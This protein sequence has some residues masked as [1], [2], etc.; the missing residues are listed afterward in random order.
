MIMKNDAH[1]I[2]NYV[3]MPGDN[4]LFDANIWLFIYGPQGDPRDW[5]TRTYSKSLANALK[6][7]SSLYIDV[8]VLSEF[9]NRYA[10]LEHKLQKASPYR[11]KTFRDSS[12]FKPIAKHIANDVRRIVGLCIRT[13]SGFE[14]VDIADLLN[15]F[16]RGNSDFN[17]QVL[18][19]LCQT[20]GLTLVTHDADFKDCGVA[21]L[22]ANRRLLA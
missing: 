19:A 2:T 15:E 21:I 16:G 6:A 5:R 9:I 1:R 12:A 22:T 13:E 11:F 4:L 8:L 7:G 14:S 20:R 3:F 10:R 18:T 17:D